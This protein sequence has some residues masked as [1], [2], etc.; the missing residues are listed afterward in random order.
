M[1]KA[2]TSVHLQ[3]LEHHLCQVLKSKAEQKKTQDI[4]CSFLKVGHNLIFTSPPSDST[5][6]LHLAQCSCRQDPDDFLFGL[7][8]QT[9]PWCFPYECRE[10]GMPPL[11]LPLGCMWIDWT[12]LAKRKDGEGGERGSKLT[13]CL[14]KSWGRSDGETTKVAKK[15]EKRWGFGPPSLR[16]QHVSVKWDISSTVKHFRCSFLHWL[17]DDWYQSCLRNAESRT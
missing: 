8:V 16:L 12:S 1:L 9:W 17:D 10:S 13:C 3:W 15:K 2:S 5:L 6:L 14:K 4:L 7:A 11:F